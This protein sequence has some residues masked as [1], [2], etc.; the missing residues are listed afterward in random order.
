MALNTCILKVLAYNGS[1]S[2]LGRNVVDKRLAILNSGICSFSGAS[3]LKGEPFASS[4]QLWNP[5][6][7]KVPRGGFSIRGSHSGG[8]VAGS[9]F[10][11]QYPDTSGE[12]STLEAL[13]DS[14]R[15]HGPA[16]LKAPPTQRRS[17]HQ[18]MEDNIERAIFD[19]RFLTL[20]GV[21]GSLLGSML[22][23]LQGSLYVVHSFKEYI[24]AYVLN[25]RSSQ[26]ILYLVEAVDVYLMGTVMLIFGMGL[27]E[28][29]VSTIEVP[30][31][32]GNAQNGA[33]SPGKAQTVRGSS[34]FGLFTLQ[35]RPKWLEIRSLDELKT[36]L[37]HVIVMIML[38]G[39]FEKSK[40]VPIH[41]GL[42]LLFFS[43]TI[44]LAASCLY[45][46]SML[47]QNKPE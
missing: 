36:K 22:C 19:C 23:F 29:F 28:L 46:L 35:E 44:F 2:S 20:F 9:G 3:R 32:G 26:V 39:M 8:G 16:N 30:A 14:D 11:S 47:H 45:L 21:V 17:F 41:S 38:V 25:I 10:I 40:R 18:Q 37:G 31:P 4:R 24:K 5:S 27:Y 33:P 1:Y 42:D 12:K 43:G 13:L 34:F 6:P 7:K 15:E